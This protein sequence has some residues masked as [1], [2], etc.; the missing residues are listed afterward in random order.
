MALVTS[1]VTQQIHL[2]EVNR[3]LK[4]KI[5]NIAKRKQAKQALKFI[6]MRAFAFWFADSVAAPR[7]CLLRARTDSV[8]QS[9]NDMSYPHTARFV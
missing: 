8:N 6:F 4:H 2:N 5:D 1:T 9:L 3:K 7:V